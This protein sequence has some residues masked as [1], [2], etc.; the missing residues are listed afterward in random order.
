[1]RF[2]NSEYKWV[3][4]TH[5]QQA[6]DLRAALFRRMRA[7]NKDGAK[8]LWRLVKEYRAAIMADLNAP[9]YGYD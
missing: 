8:L 3:R 4:F 2:P 6:R 5:E 9:L 1:M 7:E